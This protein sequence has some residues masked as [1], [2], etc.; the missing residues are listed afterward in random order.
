MASTPPPNCPTGYPL[1]VNL[2][3]HQH[4]LLDASPTY[5]NSNPSAAASDPSFLLSSQCC[6]V[7]TQT[8]RMIPT[9]RSERY[10]DTR[11]VIKNIIITQI[12]LHNKFY[13]PQQAFYNQ[14]KTN[15]NIFFPFRC[16]R[17]TEHIQFRRM[18]FVDKRGGGSNRQ[19]SRAPKC[20]KNLFNLRGNRICQLMPRR[21]GNAVSH[22]C[23]MIPDFQKKIWKSL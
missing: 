8:G 19:L 10:K 2:G 14:F 9:N 11:Q 4:S 15:W 12:R 20:N 6:D 1:G 18:K 3:Q 7:V 17:R 22:R 16:M 21:F 5:D 13:P 23:D